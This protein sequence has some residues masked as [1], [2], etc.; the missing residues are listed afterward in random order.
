[1]EKFKRTGQKFLLKFNEEEKFFQKDMGWREG[2]G[3]IY[4]FETE[5]WFEKWGEVMSIHRLKMI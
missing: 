3:L 1:M 2:D 5:N 4:F